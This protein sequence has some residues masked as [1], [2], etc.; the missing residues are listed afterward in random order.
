MSLI[1]LY[2]GAS[3]WGVLGQLDEGKKG[4]EAGVKSGVAAARD[5]FKA[6]ASTGQYRR[7]AT[8]ATQHDN[9]IRTLAHCGGLGEES[10]SYISSSSLDGR[11]VVWDL[12][13]IGVS[14]AALQL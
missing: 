5:M 7:S 1:C 9:T 14:M 11:L 12:A 13:Q 2:I 3:E 6:K 10:L 4:D 8:L